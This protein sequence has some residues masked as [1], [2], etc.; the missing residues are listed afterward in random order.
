MNWGLVLLA[1]RRLA[2]RIA[3]FGPDVI[4]STYPAATLVLGELRARGE[5]RVPAVSAITDLAGLR[6]W[7]HP[8]VDVHL[9]THPESAAE[10][11]ELAPRTEIR[12]GQRPHLAGVRAW[13][14]TRHE[15]RVA[16]SGSTPETQVVVVS[17]GG[18]AVGDLSGAVA[19]TL[20]RDARQRRLPRGPQR[21]GPRR[22][23]G[24]SSATRR[25]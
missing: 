19:E 24:R 7:T 18:W 16:S 9:I 15:S 22:A 14:S 20:G 1:R 6:S 25:G 23:R 4:V 21:G 11:R 2:A 5:L 3:A 8:D 17:G 13:S 12:A 10:V